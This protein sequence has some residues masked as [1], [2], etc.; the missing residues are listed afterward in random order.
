M[1]I[2]IVKASA[3]GDIVQ[4]F[5]VLTYL[6]SRF[7]DAEIDWVVE[8]PFADLVKAHPLVHRVIGINTKKWRSALFSKD[9]WQE[10]TTFVKEL[11]QHTYDAVFDLQGNVKSGLV[12]ALCKSPKKVGFGRRSAPE[13]LNILF[14]N[15]RFNP[16]IG[17]NIREDYLFLARSTYGDTSTAEE[18][19]VQLRT[20]SDDKKAIERILSAS[21]I[22][23]GMKVMVCPGSAWPNKQVSE[24]CLVDFLK[25][26][27]KKRQ[28]HYLFAWGSNE[29]KA[30]A[31]RLHAH[32]PE[33][34]VVMD[35][36]SLPALQ[37]LMGRVDLVVAMD[38]LPLHLAATTGTPTFSVFGASS[39]NKYK[40]IG[41]QHRAF[42][43]PCPYGRTFVKRCP[44]LRTCPTGACVKDIN[45]DALFEFFLSM[46][47]M[48]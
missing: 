30:M 18:D 33:N 15:E 48:D 47:N 46:D 39:A 32:F 29:E 22:Q 40:P 37:N 17:Q 26:M 23:G 19:D 12:T 7:P 34:S 27:T 5:P 24:Q 28:G 1:K 9:V 2:L 31:G 8:K 13:R 4:A 35:R 14:T 6:K 41:K 16:P 25:A 21:A 10:M 43:G 45:G 38:S 42:Q 20:S 11:R 36:V 44:V 3:L